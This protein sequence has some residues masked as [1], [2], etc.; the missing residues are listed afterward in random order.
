[1]KITFN[2]AA[3]LVTGS[4]YLLNTN[5]INFLVDCGMF[6]GLD[7]NGRNLEFNF[8]PSNIAF[9]LLTHAHID[10][11]GLIPKLFR[12][13]FTGKIFATIPT[14]ELSE[15]LLLDSAKIQNDDRDFRSQSSKFLYNTDDVYLALDKMVGIKM[16]EWNEYMGIE[17][18]YVRAGHILGASSILIRSEGSILLFS[19]DIG[20]VDQSLI[21]SYERDINDE[22]DYIIME[23]LYGGESH[24]RRDIS[25]QKM[26]DVIN[27]TIEYNANVIIPVFAVHRAQ[28]ITLCLKN[29][30]E[31]NRIKKDVQI[32]LDGYLP[33][34]TTEL[35]TKY[36]SDTKNSKFIKNPFYFKNLKLIY[37]HRKSIGLLKRKSAVILAGSGMCE[38]G[39]I[40]NHL[41]KA[42]PNKKNSIIFVGYQAEDTLGREILNGNETV[43]I[44][45]QKVKV[46]ARIVELKGFS[47]HAD[48]EDLLDWLNLK[49]N[50][51]LK[52][53]FLTHAQEEKSINFSKQLEEKGY[54]TY[55]PKLF[56]SVEM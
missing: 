17:F 25:I 3:R 21:P 6:Q 16:D 38:G 10:H 27:E 9:V 2:G 55:I 30:L 15:L 51:K 44:D 35:Y 18:K 45:R 4:C 43:L 40:L 46:K 1:M 20:R 33:I 11:S 19:G 32:F 41:P 34:M 49:R 54:S 14:I 13:G 23:S 53:V 39:R 22:I 50:A 47:A 26:I 5:N 29:T 31:S 36:I 56:E 28:E 7:D 8:D 37:E 42:L 52:K 48:N 24:E 12:E